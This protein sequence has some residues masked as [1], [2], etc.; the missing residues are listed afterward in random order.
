MQNQLKPVSEVIYGG[1]ASGKS[2]YALSIID[3]KKTFK[4]GIGNTWLDICRLRL[5]STKRHENENR[6]HGIRFKSSTMKTLV[7]D[8]EA[9]KDSTLFIDEWTSLCHYSWFWSRDQILQK[10]EEIFSAINHNLHI[11]K[12]VFVCLD[13]MPY[14][15]F[16]LYKKKALWNSV[17]FTL[18][19]TITKIEYRIPTYHCER[20]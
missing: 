8:I 4:L 12:V 20:P 19:N 13:Y 3:P 10:V 9:V 2:T 15:P 5:G 17:I 16:L 7:R 1:L 11:K 18:A 6:Q 14:L